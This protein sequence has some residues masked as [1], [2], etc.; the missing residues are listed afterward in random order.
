MY[1]VLTNVFYNIKLSISITSMALYKQGDIE[2]LAENWSNIMVDVE[3]ERNLMLEPTLEEMKEVHEIILEF[4]RNNKRKIYGGF[5]LNLLVKDKDKKD[6]IYKDNKVPDVD[7]YSPDPIGDLM[8]LCNILHNTGYKAVVG[9]E[10]MHQETYS[11][12]VNYVRYC[13][14]SYVPRNI[15]NKMQFVEIDKLILIHPHFMFI[16]YL[17]MMTDPLISYWRFEADLKSY[18]RFFLLQKHYPFPSPKNEMKIKN[19]SSTIQ[20]A[21]DMIFQFLLNRNTVIVTGLYAYNYYLYE[22][23]ILDSNESNNMLLLQ[24]PYYEFISSDYRSDYV[25]LIN[26]LKSNV[27]V[28]QDRLTSTEF[29]PFFQFTGNSVEIYVDKQLICRIYN[30]NK[31]CFPYLDLS[32]IKFN[33]SANSVEK[34]KKHTIRMGTFPLILLYG[35]LSIMRARTN[36]DIQNKN[37]YYQFVGNLLD[38]RN[39]YFEKYKKN[40]L[41]DTPFREFV[42][43]CIGEAIQPDRQRRLLIESRKKKNKRYSFTYEPDN[44]V[45]EPSS[46]YEFAN[47][48]GNVINNPKNLKLTEQFNEDDSEGNFDDDPEGDLETD[49]NQITL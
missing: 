9:R 32:A 44:G 11:L 30:N 26:H 6:A 48:S 39:F 35:L 13:D 37:L 29:Y 31:R 15:Y 47:S 25:A 21:L 5:A 3:H 4:V 19:N 33:I 18:R 40:Y 17:R 20:V 22:S 24:V 46:H 28:P 23:K 8:K 34:H 1:C 42:V 7:L 43:K 14:I 27:I 12:S 45:R 49:E 41:D 38:A 36:D 10:A 2:L 16:D